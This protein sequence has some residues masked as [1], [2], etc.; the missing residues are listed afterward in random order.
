MWLYG[1]KTSLNLSLTGQQNWSWRCCSWWSKE[2]QQV[3][4]CSGKC[5]FRFSRRNGMFCWG[6]KYVQFNWWKVFAFMFK[7]KYSLSVLLMHTRLISVSSRRLDTGQVLLFSPKNINFFLPEKRGEGVP[8][9]AHPAGLGSQTEHR[10]HLIL[11]LI[12]WGRKNLF[13]QPHY[14]NRKPMCPTETV[15]WQEFC[16][17]VWVSTK[18]AYPPL[19]QR[20]HLLLSSGK[21]LA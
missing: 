10:I 21:M 17:K 18:P 5:H 8:S 11:P 16:K 9:M 2:Y 7:N 1:N 13:N 12:A 6:K 15:K 19:S 3:I 14:F 4:V 20:L